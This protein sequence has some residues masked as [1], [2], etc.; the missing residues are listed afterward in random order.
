MCVLPI[1]FL[2]G[3]V[4]SGTRGVSCLIL[5]AYILAMPLLGMT[6]GSTD[7]FVR[8]FL[9]GIPPY[10]GQKSTFKEVRAN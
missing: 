5:L 9:K 7:S 6:G 8:N 2:I 3:V 4:N 10:Y 1:V